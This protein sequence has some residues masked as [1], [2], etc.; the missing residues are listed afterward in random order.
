M[1]IFKCR[2]RSNKLKAA[3]SDLEWRGS[4]CLDL[5][6]K[7]RVAIGFL[8]N[9]GTDHLEKK[10]DPSDPTASHGKFIRL[11]VKYVDD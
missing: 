7:S 10:L 11:S 1:I 8:R 9:T 3:F 4:G 2:E 6:G 5:P